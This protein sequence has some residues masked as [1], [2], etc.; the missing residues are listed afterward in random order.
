MPI[1]CTRE[2]RVMTAEITGEVDH[3]RARAL[4]EELAHHIDADLPRDLTLDLRGV[5]FMDSSGIAV[6]L[7]TFRRMGELG[8]SL[9]VVHVP[10]QAGKVLRAAGVDRLIRFE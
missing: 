6:L 2:N 5:T 7:R 1:T 10:D 4:M 8:G 3:H 9:R